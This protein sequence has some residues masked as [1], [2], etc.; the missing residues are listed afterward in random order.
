[1]LTSFAYGGSRSWMTGENAILYSTRFDMFLLLKSAK[2]QGRD[3]ALFATDEM[4]DAWMGFGTAPYGVV[5]GAARVYRTPGHILALVTP[6]E[7][8]ATY[9][10]WTYGTTQLMRTS[11]NYPSNPN[12][13]FEYYDYSTAGGIAETADTYS[14]STKAAQLKSLLLDELLPNEMQRPL[15]ASM[16]SGQ[17]SSQQGIIAYYQSLLTTARDSFY[18]YLSRLCT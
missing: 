9:Y 8:L 13:Q 3:Y 10:N 16:Q 11:A 12:L 2:A 4:V 1:M 5:N 7:K 15:P 14:S 18:C 6:N 17:A